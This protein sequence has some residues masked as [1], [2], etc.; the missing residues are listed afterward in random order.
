MNVNA[1]EFVP[2]RQSARTKRRGRGEVSRP[3]F[4]A[5]QSSTDTERPR[6]EAVS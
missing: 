3:K 4:A 6:K 1:P 5:A 2:A